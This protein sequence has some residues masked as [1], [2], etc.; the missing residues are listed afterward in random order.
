MEYE[1]I[2]HNFKTGDIILFEGEGTFSS[3]IRC[4]TNSVYSHIGLI[5]KGEDIP[6]IVNGIK[7]HNKSGDN[8]YL[9]HSNKGSISK[10]PDVVSNSIKSGVQLN[11]F[12]KVIEYYNGNIYYEE[13]ITPNTFNGFKNIEAHIKNLST[14]EYESDYTE[15]FFAAYDGPCG[16]NSNNT[17][18]LFCSELVAYIYQKYHILKRDSND[19]PPN[20]YTPED[21]SFEHYRSIFKK[22]FKVKEEIQVTI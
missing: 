22:G 2:K 4:V 13:L 9:W 3:L 7:K 19:V 21:F 20:E 17:Y 1:S 10:I 18:E 12:S 15:L 16:M 11:V 14:K 5:I 8:I 6:S